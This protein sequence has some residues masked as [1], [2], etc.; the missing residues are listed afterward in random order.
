MSYILSVTDKPFTF[1]VI[2]LSVAMLSVVMLSVAMLSVIMLNV[3]APDHQLNC[4]A[5]GFVW[6]NCMGM[7]LTRLTAN[8]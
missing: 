3:V 5:L 8:N 7:V 4:N 2:M 6:P 1:G